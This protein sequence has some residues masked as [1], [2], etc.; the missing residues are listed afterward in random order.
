MPVIYK[1]NPWQLPEL[2]DYPLWPFHDIDFWHL[3]SLVYEVRVV[4]EGF[5]AGVSFYP[6]SCAQ[7]RSRDAFL[8]AGLLMSP[9]IYN[10]GARAWAFF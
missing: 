5:P 4:E 1:T 9:A 7:I 2:V 10:G 3:G 8:C 6:K